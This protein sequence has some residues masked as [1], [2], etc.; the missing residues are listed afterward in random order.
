MPELAE[1]KV[2]QN[3]ADLR[4]QIQEADHHRT[5]EVYVEKK[6]Q[7]LF[8]RILITTFHFNGLLLGGG[9]AF[10][11]HRREIKAKRK[12]RYTFLKIFLWLHW[13]FL[14]KKLIKEP[15]S[16]QLRRRLE[17]L[18]ATYIKL[19]QILSLR[20]DILPKNITDELKMLLDSLPALP[21]DRYMELVEEELGQPAHKIFANVNSNTLGSASLAQTHRATLRTGEEVVIKLLKP[22]TRELILT[23]SKIIRFFGSV[24]EI[25]LPQL[26]PKN[27]FSE[28]CNYTNKEVDLLLEA[29][30][31]E[32]FA[33]NFTKHPDIVFPKIYKHCT[34]SNMLVMEF[35]R[36]MKPDERAA[37]VLTDEEKD[38][39]VDLGALS[40]I[41]MLYQD[42]FFHADLHPGN[43][44]ILDEGK[45]GFIDL[46]M[47]GR[48]EE[49]TR[50]SMLY[51]Y[52]ALVTGD[53][54][55]AARYIAQVARPGRNSDPEGFRKEFTT[56]AQRWV[57]NPNFSEFSL[58]QLIFESTMLGAKYRM[59]FPLE[60]VLMVKAMITFEGV[61]QVIQ[62]NF[63]VAKISKKHIRKLILNEVNPVE[64]FKHS[65]QNA[66]ELFDMI[67]RSPIVLVEMFKQTERKLHEP[68]QGDPREGMKSVVFGGFC[69]LGGCIMAAN[70]MPWQAYTPLILL[71]A[72]LAWKG[73]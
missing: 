8:V 24:L 52:N 56:V 49:S 16:V 18:G 51:Y 9:F 63:D 25:F 19:G 20:E 62:P 30:N 45:V 12:F 59:F 57:R 3:G 61:G 40:I 11:R 21:F 32:L 41:Q 39:V 33:A 69:V 44:L 29:Q 50:K 5:F 54:E 26:Q 14:N 1:S 15:F 35:I 66:P 2:N 68:P 13:P 47:V 60:M 7:S 42:G 23:D 46:G 73:K 10:L 22:G 31:A 28:F 55:G 58:G 6:P 27:M 64:L 4:R 43:L 53:A 48:F 17:M 38:K 71:G 70:Y 36:G 67:M 65:M 37:K 72:Y 34:T